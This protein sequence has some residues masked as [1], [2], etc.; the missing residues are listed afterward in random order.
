MIPYHLQLKSQQLQLGLVRLRNPVIKRMGTPILKGRNAHRKTVS[1][2]LLKESNLNMA[3]TLFNKT[4]NSH[5]DSNDD[6][7]VVNNFFHL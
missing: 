1:V 7:N 5:S 6:K 2:K 4:N 3:K